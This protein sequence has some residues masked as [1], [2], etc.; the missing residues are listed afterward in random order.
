MHFYMALWV[1]ITDYVIYM[2]NLY[3]FFFGPVSMGNFDAYNMHIS[4]AFRICIRVY[5]YYMH[6]KFE[7]LLRLL[8]WVIFMH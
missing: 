1:C 7:D 6:E 3:V 5:A 8:V 4:Y 2:H